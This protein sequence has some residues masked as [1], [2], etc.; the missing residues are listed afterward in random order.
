MK[1][2]KTRTRINNNIYEKC[3]NSRKLA[4]KNELWWETS[5]FSDDTEDRLFNEPDTA[6][7]ASSTHTKADLIKTNQLAKTSFIP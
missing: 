7:R 4:S 2:A 3:K 1:Y 5:C 6:A